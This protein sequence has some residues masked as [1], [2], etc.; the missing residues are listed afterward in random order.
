MAEN[1]SELNAAL[2][3]FST[4]NVN[5]VEFIPSFAAP[6][7]ASAVEESTAEATAEEQPSE[8]SA[9]IG[10]YFFYFICFD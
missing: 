3:T 4:L 2:N 10:I 6:K 8:Q 9:N 7:D 1:D 5:A